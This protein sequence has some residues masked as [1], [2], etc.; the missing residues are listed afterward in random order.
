M[1]SHGV[2]SV[3]AL[4]ATLE[5]Y[6]LAK[7]VGT[8]LIGPLEYDGRIVCQISLQ[9]LPMGTL[10]D[11]YLD[12]SKGFRK[13]SIWNARL[14]LWNTLIFTAKSTPVSHFF[15]NSDTVWLCTVL[16]KFI[17]CFFF[18]FL[19]FLCPQVAADHFCHLVPKQTGPPR[20]KGVGGEVQNRGLL[21]RIRSLHHA[22][23]WWEVV[24]T[25]WVSRNV[26]LLLQKCQD[27]F[28]DHFF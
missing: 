28:C 2:V 8:N 16:C 13:C 17:V 4:I 5:L 27:G 11:G 23:W 1:A 14:I 15:L 24:T 6:L 20:R 3:L 22:R 21:P 18:F 25:H 12:K 26:S 10:P 9:V 19:F 7:L